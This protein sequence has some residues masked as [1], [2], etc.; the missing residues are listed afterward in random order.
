MEA[1]QH[2]QCHEIIVSS[3]TEA[4]SKIEVVKDYAAL[5][6]LSV[7]WRGQADHRW[8][9]TSSLVRQLSTVTIPTDSLLNQ[10]EDRILED[11]ATWIAEFAEAPFTEPLARLAYMQHHGIPTRLLDFT[12]NEWMALFFAAE[13]NDDVD[14]RLFALLVDTA[15]VVSAT[16][17]AKPWRDWKVSEVR[18]WDPV[19][20]EISFP[21]IRAQHSV[22]AVGRLPST[23]PRRKA[24]DELLGKERDLLAEEIRSILSIP[25]KLCP[26]DPIPPGGTP[27]IGLTLR[28]HI[29]KQSMRRGLRKAGAGRRVCPRNVDITPRSMYPDADG[30]RSHSPFLRGLAEGVILL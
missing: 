19:A 1:I 11:G 3:M 23:Q 22:F 2:Y 24:W 8:S 17:A 21:R 27:P 29:S 5:R 10:V 25:F 15:D 26:F 9:L 30:M 16:P 6:D 7:F 20:S 18:I 4:Q 14:G 12:S 28:L 13:S